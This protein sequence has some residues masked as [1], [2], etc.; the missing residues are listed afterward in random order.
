MKKLLL[1][2]AMIAAMFQPAKAQ[3]GLWSWS[4]YYQPTTWSEAKVYFQ[5]GWGTSTI[6]HQNI[7][8]VGGEGTI[9]DSNEDNTIEL[10]F[11]FLH[12][13]P[14]SWTLPWRNGKT[15]LNEVGYKGQWMDPS[16]EWLYMHHIIVDEG[17]THVGKYWFAGLEYLQE[18]SL[19]RSV[20]SIG[21]GA[22]KS[23]KYFKLFECPDN[24]E[25]IGDKVFEGCEEL[26]EFNRYDLTGTYKISEKPLHIGNRTFANCGNLKNF[27]FT[28]NSTIGNEAFHHT[29]FESINLKS[30][31][32]FGT[33]TFSKCHSL[34]SVIIPDNSTLG[35][36]M[37]DDCSKL[38]SI[39]FQGKIP[40]IPEAT[41]MHCTNL[42]SINIPNS[43]TKIDKWA[44]G[45]T[46]LTSI[47][48]P[49]S[50]TSIEEYA[51]AVSDKLTSA[52]IPNSITKIGRWA[53]QQTSLTS[54]TIPGSVK[55]I[56]YAAFAFCKK[57][58][59][60]KICEGVKIISDAAFQTCE[61]LE[62]VNLPASLDSIG[63]WAFGHCY[64]LKLIECNNEIPPA[65][66]Q[67]AFIESGIN[68]A[69]ICVPSGS[70]EAYKNAPV[71]KDFKNIGTYPA[72]IHIIN[73][74]DF[75]VNSGSRIKLTA[76]LTPH[77]AVPT[78]VWTSSNKSIASVVDGIITAYNTGE[79]IITATTIN[80]IFKDS[81]KITIKLGNEEVTL[82]STKH[83]TIPNN[84]V[85]LDDMF[86]NN[87]TIETVT[88]G[89]NV[90]FGKNTF[91]GC[92]NLKSI[93]FNGEISKITERMFQYC[94]SLSSID[95]PEGVTSIGDFA[96][97]RCHSLRTIN[98]P[99]SVTS[100]NQNAFR[101][102]GL[103]SVTVPGSIKDIAYSAFFWCTELASVKLCEGVET[104]GIEVF[105]GCEKLEKISFP[106]SLK[107]VN[108]W[109]FTWSNNIKIIECNGTTPPILH[110]QSFE[111]VDLTNITVYVPKGSVDAYKNAPVWKDF[112]KIV[113]F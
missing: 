108:A 83:I 32:S 57:L 17:I 75:T 78:I 92:S 112:P 24:I 35:K 84:C 5:V 43:V 62:T 103:T 1:M 60:A 42:T 27:N 63:D 101:L 50:V 65:T 18:V 94:T 22:F 72:G 100:I 85:L 113:T 39:T 109:A 37:F 105:K 61:T 59:S 104:I 33:G 88:V 82:G 10:P 67:N 68:K 6:N 76:A 31:I 97:E 26:C 58:T 20:R 71:W 15:K 44:F 45:H 87:K 8:F 86:T 66:H 34:E 47:T 29:G 80:G 111:E 91:S 74:K 81:C 40:E 96:F 90:T 3:Y 102:S 21:E 46:G 9:P 30:G 53:F 23:C 64:N 98:I 41:F 77:N 13:G 36:N 69:S 93:T 28:E 19:A 99:N 25:S 106:A 95:I 49:N 70:E 52:T 79:T 12:G 11:S 89:D 38:K 56:E 14:Y 16:P 107:Y 51:F 7:L 48:I 2:V 54:I 55:N 110:T 4:Y 73:G